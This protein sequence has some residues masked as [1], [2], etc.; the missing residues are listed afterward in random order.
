MKEGARQE[1][2]FRNMKIQSPAEY[3]C[4]PQ[5]VKLGDGRGSALR[6]AL[7][8]ARWEFWG[9]QDFWIAPSVV[10]G[11]QQSWL[12]EA[13]WKGETWVQEL[14]RLEG[15]WLSPLLIPDSTS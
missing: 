9:N 4:P 11:V 7:K 2:G 1:P 13:L 15:P 6:P 12:S 5:P 3:S 10:L 14:E 8:Q